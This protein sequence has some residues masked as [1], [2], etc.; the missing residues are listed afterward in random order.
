[1]NQITTL[2][3]SGELTMTSLEISELVESRH[4]KVKQ[5]IERLSERGV[6]T[7]PPMGESPQQAGRALFTFFQAKRESAIALL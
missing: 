3:N 7:L 6:I 4:D 1:M 5:S 2:V